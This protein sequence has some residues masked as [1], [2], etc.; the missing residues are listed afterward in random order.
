MLNGGKPI[1]FV[2]KRHVVVDGQELFVIVGNH[3]VLR[4]VQARY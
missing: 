2:K 3:V 1:R 4:S